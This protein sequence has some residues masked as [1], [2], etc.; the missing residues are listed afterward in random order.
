[1]ANIKSDFNWTSDTW[2]IVKKLITRKEFLVE[3]QINSYNEFLEKGL[4]NII[5]QFNPIILNY[6]Y[7]SDQLFFKFS[8]DSKYK[9]LQIKYCDWT[10]FRDDEELFKL[11]GE[12]I[13]NIESTEVELIDLGEKLKANIQDEVKFMND[14]FDSSL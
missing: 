4:P 11:V 9:K 10:E 5:S 13:E 1:M 12:M 14:Y 8:M 6:D 7:V 3:H 2:K